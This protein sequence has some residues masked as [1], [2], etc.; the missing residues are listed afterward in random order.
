MRINRRFRRLDTGPRLTDQQELEMVIGPAGKSAFKDDDARRAAYFAHRAEV[1][2]LVTPDVQPW[3]F[4]VYEK[5][6]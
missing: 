2:E 6:A 3:A 4:K 1:L 5:G